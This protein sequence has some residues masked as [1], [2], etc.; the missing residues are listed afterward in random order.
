MDFVMGLPRSQAG[1]DSIWVV[2]ERLTKYAH[3]ISVRS[4]SKV[5]SLANEYFKNI[6]SI[7]G[8]P[9]RIVSDCDLMF[10]SR[11]CRNLHLTLGSQLHVGTTYH[12]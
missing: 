7:H 3:F 8:V 5:S 1:N 2:V 11:F 4:N 6:V 10:T 9:T 12:P